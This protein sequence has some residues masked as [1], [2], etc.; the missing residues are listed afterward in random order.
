MGGLRRDFITAL[1]TELFEKKIFITREGTK[2][3]FLNPNFVMDDEFLYVIMQTN[4]QVDLPNNENIYRLFYT[5]IGTLLSFILVNDCGI[6]NN[7]SSFIVANFYK[8]NFTP[9]DYLYFMS[10]DFPEYTTSII[11]L[12]KIPDDIEMTGI[13]FNDIYGIIAIDTNLTSTNIEQYLLETAKF[14]M[15]KTCLRK[16]IDINTTISNDQDIYNNYITKIRT[17]LAALQTGI[18]N[19]IKITLARANLTL[20]VINSWL[21]IQPITYAIIDE[22][23]ANFHNTMTLAIVRIPIPEK[24]TQLQLFTNLFIEYVLQNKYGKSDEIYFAYINKLLL[25]W[26]GSS[27]YNEKEEYK[28]IIQDTLTQEH[29]P[30]S[31]TCFYLIDIPNY[32]ASSVEELGTVIYTKL[33]IAISNVERGMGFSGGSNYN[34]II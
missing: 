11:N 30:R 21:V 20:K 4:G 6:V 31:H 18:S 13:E 25:F 12:M 24:Q 28:I 34:N 17:N 22:L 15:T 32:T 16:N 19:D 27:F 33:E 1:T 26:S 10:E 2:K 14:M 5:F 23:I 8:R 3:Y 9:D 7:L 29:F